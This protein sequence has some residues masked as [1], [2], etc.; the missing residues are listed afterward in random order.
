MEWLPSPEAVLA[1]ARG[2][3]FVSITNLS[4]VPVALPEGTV[5]LLASEDVP[6]GHLPPDVTAWLRRERPSEPRLVAE[7]ELEMRVR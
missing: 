2:T 5:L 7:E 1:F 4:P 3:Q 6:N